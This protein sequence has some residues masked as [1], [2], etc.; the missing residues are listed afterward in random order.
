MAELP[1]G[2]KFAPSDTEI[3]IYLDNKVNGH[4][5]PNVKLDLV[6]ELD[7]YESCPQDHQ[8]LSKEE[9]TYIFATRVG[10]YQ[11]ASHHSN[12]KTRDGKGSWKINRSSVKSTQGTKKLLT[13]YLKSENSSGEK[14]KRTDWHML[15]YALEPANAEVK[16]NEGKVN[17]TVL[18]QITKGKRYKNTEVTDAKQDGDSSPE[19]GT[20]LDK[21]GVKLMMNKSSQENQQNTAALANEEIILIDFFSGG[22]EN[23]QN[24]A[25]PAS[26]GTVFTDLGSDG[27]ENQQN[28]AA[29]ANKE[30]VF[31]DSGSDRLEN[32]QIT[33]APASEGTVFTDFFSSGV[34]N[35][36]NT[37]APAN[38]NIVL[39]DMG[40]DGAENQQNAAAPA[41]EGTVFT[42][43]FSSGVENHE[44]TTAPANENIV[45]TDMGSDGVE[46]QQNTAAPANEDIVLTDMGS[47]GIENQQ[48]TAAPANEDIVLTDL[49]S[50]GVE[51]SQGHDLPKNTTSAA[52][53]D[54]DL[55]LRLCT[56]SQN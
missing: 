51:S 38:E 44:N 26:E 10:K 16:V 52:E 18:C 4:K 8:G 28:T 21:S 1:L 11:T 19:D 42:D 36:E 30:I 25:A 24:A 39:T 48:N 9:C 49:G 31:T 54:V 3:F 29:P 20:G 27:V 7:I 50:D 37:T 35:H 40:S 12:R 55:S 2:C 15:E 41:S 13:Y 53:N 23:Q 56:G 5:H 17:E 32:Q 14:E 46:N 22:V 47:D 6:K 43:F 33:A 45:L 34:E